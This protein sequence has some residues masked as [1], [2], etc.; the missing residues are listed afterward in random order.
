MPSVKLRRDEVTTS[1]VV[2]I[3]SPTANMY[4]CEPCPKC[5]GQDRCM[6]NDKPGLIQCDECGYN[7]MAVSINGEEVRDDH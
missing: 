7:E 5:K 3:N 4:G 2:D 6:F 1:Q